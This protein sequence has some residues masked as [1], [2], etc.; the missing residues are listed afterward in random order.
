MTKDEVVNSLRVFV[1]GKAAADERKRVYHGRG[2]RPL[3][4]L[5]ALV[6]HCGLS[7]DEAKALVEGNGG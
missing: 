7:F 4:A 6:I 3:N 5:W 2:L 1:A